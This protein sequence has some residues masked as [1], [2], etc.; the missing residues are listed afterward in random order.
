MSAS[1]WFRKSISVKLVVIGC[2]ILVL[3]I[4]TLML[5]GLVYERKQRQSEAISEVSEKW[6]NAQTIVGPVISIPYLTFDKTKMSNIKGFIYV[7]PDVLKVDGEIKP[8]I[9]KRGIFEAAVYKS[10]LKISGQFKGISYSDLGI[11][12]ENI[13]WHDAY[14]SLGIPDMRGIKETIV[15]NFGSKELTFESGAKAKDLFE[16]GVSAPLI[17]TAES[18]EQTFDFNLE[19]KINGSEYLYFSPLGKET[20]VSIKSDWPSPSFAGKFLPDSREVT[21]QGFTANWKV[22]DLNRNFPQIWQDKAYDIDNA[23]FGVDLLIP[24]DHYQK[25]QRSVKYAILVIFLTFL[26][27]FFVEVIYKKRIHPFQYLLVGLALVI[28]YA[29]LLSLA[30]NINFN[31]AYL[32]ASL[33]TTL[34]ISLYSRAIF[35][36]NNMALVIGGILAL[37]YI[38]MYVI[39]QSEDYAFLMGSVF[40]FMILAVV[41]YISR[42]IKW[43]EDEQL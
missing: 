37:L 39:L 9:L 40:L 34:L 7:L 43:Y 30:E 17:L 5:Y 22:L 15:M 33:A 24:A 31:I 26:A 27:Y 10:N 8:E 6:G 42:N 21:A 19:V 32:I 4:P 38:F 14:I 20:Q 12:S 11:S 28:F 41:M 23:E 25:T 36:K 1:Q 18:A 3:L 35:K 16:S 13:Q 29:L 2:L